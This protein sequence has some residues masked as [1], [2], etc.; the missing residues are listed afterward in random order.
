MKRLLYHGLLIYYVYMMF[1]CQS[2]NIEKGTICLNLGDYPM[3]IEF[4]DR[5][6]RA[7][8]DNYEARIGLG[9]ALLQK[10]V[11]DTKDTAS[12]KLA[13]IHIEAARTLN[14]DTRTVKLL[15]QVWAE[16]SQRL[17]GI[18]DTIAALEALSSALQYDP[19]N[20]ELVNRTGILYFRLGYAEKAMILFKKAMALDTL[21]AH[22]YF[23]LGMVYWSNNDF[24][25]ARDT[26]LRAL[27]LDSEDED[28]LYWFARAE[29]MV[30][31]K[32]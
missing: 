26:W 15:S 24:V 31:E 28:I 18:G 3:A 25:R 29:K 1:G 2:S 16:Y 13:L 6:V 20:V 22:S 27:S 19:E 14:P 4:F 30:R 21:H 12:W 8:P 32:Q 9:K 7:Q 17:F 11:D 5:E 23:N 10:A